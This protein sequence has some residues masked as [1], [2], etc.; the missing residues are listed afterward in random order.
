MV[1]GQN[2]WKCMNFDTSRT[3]RQNGFS[4]FISNEKI[5]GLRSKEDYNPKPGIT[6]E[7]NSVLCI[8]KQEWGVIYEMLNKN[9]TVNAEGCCQLEIL[10]NFQ[11]GPIT[12]D[13]QKYTFH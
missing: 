11:N 12:K 1:C 6:S 3:L 4:I 13:M 10:Y 8:V 2:N 5:N 7:Q 9:E